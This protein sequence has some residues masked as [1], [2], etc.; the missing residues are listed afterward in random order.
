MKACFQS[1]LQMQILALSI[2]GI[3]DKSLLLTYD[4]SIISASSSCLRPARL[5]IGII[6]SCKLTSSRH[7][8]GRKFTDSGAKTPKEGF[9]YNCVVDRHDRYGWL[10]LEQWAFLEMMECPPTWEAFRHEV[11]SIGCH[12]HLCNVWA[13]VE[14]ECM[15]TCAKSN[16]ACDTQDDPP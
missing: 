1:I 9:N 4:S 12:G 11:T 2:N 7:V 16:G 14:H 6:Y 3:Q 5:A 15:E 10:T 13:Q 8:V